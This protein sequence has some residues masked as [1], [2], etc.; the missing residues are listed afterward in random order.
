MSI[1][2]NLYKQIILERC[3]TC[4]ASLSDMEQW[5]YGHEC[6]AC[7][8]KFKKLLENLKEREKN[9]TV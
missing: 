9:E 3:E 5:L 8:K 2:R 1:R 7:R 6:E 4:G